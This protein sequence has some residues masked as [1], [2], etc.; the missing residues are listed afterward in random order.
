MAADL[1]IPLQ[2]ICSFE[3]IVAFENRIQAK[4]L[5]HFQHGPLELPFFFQRV[6]I[7]EEVQLKNSAVCGHFVCTHT[8]TAEEQTVVSFQVKG[9]EDRV[10]GS[11]KAVCLYPHLDCSVAVLRVEAAIEIKDFRSIVIRAD[12]QRLIVIADPPG[13]GRGE[14]VLHEHILAEDID[15]LTQDVSGFSVFVRT[16]KHLANAEAVSL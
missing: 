6:M 16:G 14:N 12:L 11:L 4:F 10:S 7:C 13:E 5:A 8:E 9:R 2:L 1:E 15:H 3:H